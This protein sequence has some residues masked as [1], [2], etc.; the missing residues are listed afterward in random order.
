[1]DDELNYINDVVGTDE[2][3]V[4]E[5]EEEEEEAVDTQET[6]TQRD[7]VDTNIYSQA[8]F[9]NM[10]KELALLRKLPDVVVSL[11]QLPLQLF[12]CNLFIECVTVV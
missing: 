8:V 4:V 9:E 3:E 7:E 12:V 1:M 2:A 10:R 6:E 11:Q 5:E